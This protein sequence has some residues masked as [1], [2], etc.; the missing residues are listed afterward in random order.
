MYTALCFSPSSSSIDRFLRNARAKNVRVCDAASS[1]SNE[2]DA[3]HEVS[4]SLSVSDLECVIFVSHVQKR[5]ER[6]FRE[7][8]D[9]F[10]RAQRH[11]FYIP[12]KIREES[13]H[14]LKGLCFF[15]YT[16]NG[17]RRR[18]RIRERAERPAIPVRASA[19]V[20]VRRRRRRRR[21]IEWFG[22]IRCP[23]QSTRKCWRFV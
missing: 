3:R 8:R 18:R 5:S 21:R 7:K 2:D 16:S 1:R 23:V 13:I 9:V 17:V 6:N 22:R 12:Q 15:F 19:G 11:Q 20:A 4:R 14:T 10:F